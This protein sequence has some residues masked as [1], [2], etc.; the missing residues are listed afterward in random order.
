MFTAND[1][2]IKLWKLDYKI[3][4]KVGT[5]GIGPDGQLIIPKSKIVDE[6]FE[7]AEKTKFKFCH[8]YN[9]NSMSSSPDGEN[10][11]SADDLRINLWNVENNNLAFNL[12]DLKPPNIEELSEVITHVEYHP[13]RSDVFLFSSS[14]GY[15]SRCDLRV[16]SQYKSFAT[17]FMVE[18][19]PS[20]KHFFTDII[21]SVSR[22]KFSPTDDNYIFARDY[23]S[24][25][26]W[27]IRNQ[28]KPCKVFNVTD[29]LEKKLCE[30]Y[31]SE[32]IF[33]KFDL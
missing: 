4:R 17:K 26:V 7:L 2:V 18:E 14:K 16:N 5:S 21:N 9:I 20:R 15:I 3:H 10:F 13:K 33:D 6:G 28:S 24:V 22:A 30:L 12:V 23:L 32:N 11:M 1:R 8:T 31:E 29:Y 25:Q 27:D 19:D